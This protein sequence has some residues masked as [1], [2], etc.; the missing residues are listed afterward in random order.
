MN[1]KDRIIYGDSDLFQSHGDQSL[2]ENAGFDI[3]EDIKADIALYNASEDPQSFLESEAL[4]RGYKKAFEFMGCK[5]VAL[6]IGKCGLIEWEP[7]YS[8]SEDIDP[9]V[10]F[11]V[12]RKT[13]E[14][15]V[16]VS[17]GE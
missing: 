5:L 9:I 6:Q 3:S 17:F 1:T 4:I 7:R 13:G 12:F 14:K 15:I 11:E 8:F 16:S 2:I 10:S